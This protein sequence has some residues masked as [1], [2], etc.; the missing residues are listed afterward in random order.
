MR[1]K[2]RRQETGADAGEFLGDVTFHRTHWRGICRESLLHGHDRSC[3]HRHDRARIQ[4]QTCG[5]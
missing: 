4:V 2:T 5:H 1:L 3:A